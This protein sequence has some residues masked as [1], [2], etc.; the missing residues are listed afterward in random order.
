M[1]LTDYCESVK[2]LDSKN[3]PLLNFGFHLGSALSLPQMLVE[4]NLTVQLWQ[5]INLSLPLTL[6]SL[7]V[8]RF[9]IALHSSKNIAKKWNITA[10]KLHVTSRQLPFSRVP[11]ESFAGSPFFAQFRKCSC[12]L[13]TTCFPPS[14]EKCPLQVCLG[15]QHKQDPTLN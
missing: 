12:C 13:M 7:S 14:S 2:V 11:G 1:F 10:S 4:V 9:L 6:S 5:N 3:L 15:K 8:S